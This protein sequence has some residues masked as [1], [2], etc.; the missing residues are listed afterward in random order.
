MKRPMRIDPVPSKVSNGSICV[1]VKPLLSKFIHADTVNCVIEPTSVDSIFPRLASKFNSFK[2]AFFPVKNDSEL[3]GR[4][5]NDTDVAAILI[6]MALEPP[7]IIV[8]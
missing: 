6:I 5:C 3:V 1:P 2:L 4:D 8:F 7:L